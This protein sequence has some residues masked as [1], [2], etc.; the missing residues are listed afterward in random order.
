MERAHYSLCYSP[1]HQ[2]LQTYGWQCCG[3]DCQLWIEDAYNTLVSHNDPVLQM[4]GTLLDEVGRRNSIPTA[5]HFNLPPGSGAVTYSGQLA[6]LDSGYLADRIASNG[7][8]AVLLHELWHT[9]QQVND[10]LSVWGEVAT[11]NLET[12]VMSAFGMTIPAWRTSLEQYGTPGMITRDVCSMCQARE[13]LLHAT[14][15]HWIYSAEP[16]VNAPWLFPWLVVAYLPANY[17]RFCPNVV[18]LT[19]I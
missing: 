2:P 6:G 16:A 7:E 5:F 15:N 19:C 13:C 18:P 17:P 10:R 8:I 1:F 4:L 14:N 9:Q 11:Y 12:I 3:A